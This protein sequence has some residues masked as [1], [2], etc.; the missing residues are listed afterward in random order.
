M[1]HEGS[2]RINSRYT[3]RNCH[4]AHK[5]ISMHKQ[6]W[7]QSGAVWGG[8][9]V[10]GLILLGVAGGRGGAAVAGGGAVHSV[11]AQATAVAVPGA[12]SRTFPAT[13]Q[14]VTGLFLDYWTAHGG[15]DQQGYPISAP[16]IEQSALDGTPYTVQ[17]FERAV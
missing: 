15:L 4:T 3:W 13:S 11:A 8:L 7:V 16:F 12:G 14:T 2:T 6:R 1:N 10:F 9:V 17:Y 5:E